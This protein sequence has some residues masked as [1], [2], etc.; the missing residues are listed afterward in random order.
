M[1]FILVYTTHANEESAMKLSNYMVEKKIAACAN[2]FPIKSAYWWK[3]NIESEDEYV[4]ILKTIPENW[5]LLKTKIEELHPYDVPCIM[6]I[7]VEANEKYEEW[8]RSEVRQ[9]T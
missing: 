6:K 5:E 8:I 3:G 1:S 4:S 7:N 9:E 2:I